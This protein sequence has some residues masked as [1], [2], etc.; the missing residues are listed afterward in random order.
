MSIFR[1]LKAELWYRKL[2]ITLSLLALMAAAT[3]FVASPTLLEGYR[4]E[5]EQHLLTLQAATKATLA[6]MQTETDNELQSMQAKAD[7]DLAQ[8]DKQTKRIMRDLGFNLRIVHKNTDMTQLYAAFVAFDMPE[9]YIA[10]LAES[11]EITKIVHLVATLKQMV[12]WEEKPRLLVSFAPEATQAHIEKKAPMGFQIKPG[13]VYLGAVS[14]EGH[15]VG[16]KVDILGKEFE[17]ARILPPHGTAEED[18]AICMHLEDAQEVL[19]KPERISEILA[20]GCKC[21]TIERIEEITQQLELVLPEAKV[22]EH[23]VQAIA[24]EDQ[25]KLV[26][27][28]SRQTMADYRANRERILR[29]EAESQQEIIDREGE[30]RTSVMKLLTAVTSVVTPL[31]I[32]V[33]AIWVGMLAWSNVRE[34]RVEI[35]LLR[36]LGKSS[37]SIAS[38]FLGKAMLLGLVAGAVGCALGYVLAWWLA[39]VMLGVDV[40]NFT[41]S[42]VASLCAFFGTPV[43]AAMASYPPTLS[44]V[45][46]DPA[47]VLMDA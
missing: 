14:G 19:K 23:R 45:H 35:G 7:N 32:L 16:D 10:R 25:R 3:L 34:R 30:H 22:T 40:A 46:Q 41:P 15:K 42:P 2:N 12:Q 43:V 8:L 21:E 6:A 28:H 44:A 11:P 17:V 13:T 9:E 5:S 36:A 39:T 47:V 26:V 4:S 24:R 18:I 27:K 38:L 37:A 29:H 33:C 1:L 31:V 20:L